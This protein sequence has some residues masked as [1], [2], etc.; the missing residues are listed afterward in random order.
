MFSAPTRTTCGCEDKIKICMIA[1]LGLIVV[2]GALQ[3]YVVSAVVVPVLLGFY[4]VWMAYLL[5][6]LGASDERLS[7]E[8]SMMLQ[9]LGH[10]TTV[11]WL[12]EISSLA[13]VGI[14]A[15]IFVFDPGNWLIGIGSMLFF[16]PCAAVFLFMLV[17][18]SR[19]AA[20]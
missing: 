15:F 11:L 6:R 18:R 3:S 5:P 7:L 13:F 10:N 20:R 19:R 12:P 1:A 9:P 2:S 17:V 16:G 8:E 14:G 4:A